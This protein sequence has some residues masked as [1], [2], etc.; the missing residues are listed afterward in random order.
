M[1]YPNK[2]TI[3][4]TYNNCSTSINGKEIIPYTKDGELVIEWIRDTAP[5]HKQTRFTIIKLQDL[6]GTMLDRGYWGDKLTKDEID[7]EKL[8]K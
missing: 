6:E 8:L 3:R 1:K 7:K 5:Y 2:W 4:N